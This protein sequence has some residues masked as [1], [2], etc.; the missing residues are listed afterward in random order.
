MDVHDSFDVGDPC[1]LID[2]RGHHFLLHLV[3]GGQFQFHRGSVPH[4][5]IV[6]ALN[7]SFVTSDKGAE[8]VALRPRLTDYVLKMKRGAQVVYPKD[9]GP[10]LMYADIAPGTTVVEAGSGSGALTLALVRAVGPTG[11]VVSVELREDH[12]ALAAKTVRRFF[13]GT[14][15]H[16][17]LRIGDVIDVI[18]EVRPDRIVLDVPEPW[19]AAEAAA[20]G[21]APGGVFCAY[22][23]TVPQLETLHRTLDET[24][25]FVE[26]ETF[27]VFERTWNVRGRSVRPNHQM[28]G[29]TGF[30]T[31][32]RRVIRPD[33]G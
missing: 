25:A 2:D 31:T 4:A 16:L 7:G 28:V 8:L 26:A 17:E 10:I 6:G 19:L 12:A 20:N 23:P 18:P 27:E 33:A 21:L 14:P 32:A 22:L 30:I 9:T 24:G 15:E 11:R 13:G 3:D 1:L 5:D 29:H